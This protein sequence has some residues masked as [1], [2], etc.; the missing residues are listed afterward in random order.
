MGVLVNELQRQTSLKLFSF[1]NSSQHSA[2]WTDLSLGR[3]PSHSSAERRLV[4]TIKFNSY[5]GND[6]LCQGNP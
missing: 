6:C 1:F 2:Q 4:D 5:G 3:D